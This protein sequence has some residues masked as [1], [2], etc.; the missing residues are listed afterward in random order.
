MV[1]VIVVIAAIVA[2]V[3]IVLFRHYPQPSW[4]GSDS[5]DSRRSP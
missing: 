4:L 3:E 2:I 1:V 5:V